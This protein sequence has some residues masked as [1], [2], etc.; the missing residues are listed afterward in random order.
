MFELKSPIDIEHLREKF[1]VTVQ[2]IVDIF[3]IMNE[4][5]AFQLKD[6]V[7]LKKCDRAVINLGLDKMRD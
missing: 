4:P 5:D 1:N 3:K 6:E 7:N 2:D